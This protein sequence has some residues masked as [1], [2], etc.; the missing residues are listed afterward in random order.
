MMR[1]QGDVT[2]G[3][4]KRLLA[5]LAKDIKISK[6]DMSKII[7]G[8]DINQDGYISVAEVLEMLRRYIALAKT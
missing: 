6:D 8:C 7:D 3:I 4:W 1:P 5:Y 2:M